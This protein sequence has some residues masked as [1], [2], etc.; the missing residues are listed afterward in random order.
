LEMK[1]CADV[2][3]TVSGHR[4]KVREEASRREH[5]DRFYTTAYYD[6]PD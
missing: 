2:S 3:M 4:V 5:V 1:G 6:Y